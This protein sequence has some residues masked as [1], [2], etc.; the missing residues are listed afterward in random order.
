[1]T[2]PIEQP[3]DEVLTPVETSDDDDV[4]DDEPVT[5][6]KGLRKLRNEAKRLRHLLRESEANRA[7]DL[8][9]IAAYEK[10][11]VEAA[12]SAVLVDPTDL[13]VHTDEATQRS[14]NDEFGSITADRVVEAAKKLAAERPH[15]AKTQRP[16]SN[17]P[18]ESL[19]SG[20]MPAEDKKPATWYGAIHGS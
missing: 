20:A 14:F 11:A 15:L 10:R 9:R 18:I 1:M 16:P 12:A 4:D 8:A 17:Q 19:R 6:M 13:W 5:D 3:D 7:S 2:E